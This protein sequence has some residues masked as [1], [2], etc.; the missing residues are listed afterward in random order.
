MKN[1]T[2]FHLLK[3]RRFLPLFITQFLGAFNDNI[4]KNALVIL[5]TYRLAQTS[6]THEQLLVTL[7]GGIFILPFFLFS[8]TAGQLADKFDKSMLIRLV[9]CAE[10]IFML[11]A[12]Y[13]FYSANTGLLL[14]TLF[15][16]GVHSTFFGPLKYAILPDQLQE[17]ELISGNALIEAATFIAILIGTIL[18]GVLIL[19]KIG[20]LAISALI[21]SVA[22]IGLFSSFYIPATPPAQRNLKINFNFVAETW[23]II[24]YT[25]QNR[26]VFLSIL[27]ISWFWLIGA[28]FL[29]QFPNFTKNILG[30]DSA[31]ITLFLTL[32]SIGIAVGSLVCNRLLHGK[33]SAKYVPVSIFAMSFCMMDLFFAS[34]NI[35]IV[36][37]SLIGIAGFLSSLQN[38]RICFDIFFL[39]I[40]G[41]FYVV[42]LYALLQ[43]ESDTE[44]RAR[45]ISVNNILNA[46]F[47]VAAAIVVMLL[48]LL[49]LTIPQIFLCLA[50]ANIFVAFYI[51]KILPYELIQ[52]IVKWILQVLFR[53]KITGLENYEAAGKRVVI[54]ANHT[55]FLDPVLLSAFLPG[56]VMF[57]V[58]THIARQWWMKPL[59]FS[60]DTFL[61]DPTNPYATKPLIR[62]I[63]QDNKCV[64][65]PEGRITV[66]GSLMKVYEG[67]GMIADR[68]QA[69]LL[70][71]S[72]DGAQYTIFSRLRGKLKIRW[73]PQI[74]L[75]ILPSHQ[76]LVA[77]DI[78][79]RKRRQIIS[80][81][82]YDIMVDMQFTCSGYQQTLFASL[83][84][85]K[86]IFGGKQI[87]IEDVDRKPLTYH[88]FISRC[89]ILGKNIRN[90]TQTSDIIGLLLPNSVSAIT[91]FFSIL[92]Y[93]RIVA[94][95][96][97]SSG[98]HNLVSACLTAKITVIYTAKKFIRATNLSS[99]IKRLMESGVKIIYL[100]DLRKTVIFSDKV[101]AFIASTFAHSY[102][103]YHN[104]NTSAKNP[105]VVLFTSGS[106]GTPKGVVLSHE[107]IQANRYQMASRVPFS[108]QD[109]IFNA[110]PIFHS[111]GLTAGTLLPLLSGIKVFLYPSPLHYRIIPEVIYDINATITFGTATFLSNY[112]RYAHP[113][114]FYSLHYVFAGAEKLKEET[115]NLW[116]DKFGIRLLEGYG[117][118]ETAPVIAVNTPMQNKRGTV[119]RFLPGMQYKL[120]SVPGI[121]DGGRLFVSGPNVMI[122]YMLAEQPGK[123]QP[124]ANGWHDTGDIVSIDD[125]GYISIK[126][127]AKRFAKIGGE[128]VSLSAVEQYITEL[129]PN[130]QHAVLSIPDSKKGEQIVLI[131][132]FKS[133]QLSEIISFAKTKGITEISLP[134]KILVIETIPVLGTGKIDYV[135]LKTWLNEN[136]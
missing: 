120:V 104:K 98:M 135:A 101:K 58:N 18:G 59:L 1:Q 121:A 93:D 30:A 129:W 29:S 12:A 111:F 136:L 92:A 42:P 86:K 109:I 50:L 107:N 74:K 68:A 44:H 113:Y 88:Q 24:K 49:H 3:T 72:I 14:F 46:L 64:I 34:R 100:E 79:G 11:S 124:P 31:V 32:F 60:I 40:F 2:Q 103:K 66:T 23:N 90:N 127:R 132:E 89:F 33:I 10:I 73:F 95:L 106:E 91:V 26:S 45:A 80:T 36:Q 9:K 22:I 56:K 65:F 20:I 87:I 83:I 134:R 116:S 19:S 125:L 53:V 105:A 96:N 81:R 128:M 17:N 16:M 8:A 94:P 99:T 52:S 112:A 13:G 27:G 48:L 75:T 126:D 123:L 117:A 122:G 110:L 85:A 51:C 69:T 118:T 133:A 70:P 54:I 15:L 39:S 82:L 37:H 4:Y 115:Y 6:V 38:W 77:D 35:A 102:Y 25:Q 41:G 67:P 131:T 76:F 97:F 84:A 61:V 21:I 71:V 108:S 78:T 114:D 55:S 47:M 62:A 119:G 28:T 7:A 43:T 63:K 5:L 130:Y 57:A